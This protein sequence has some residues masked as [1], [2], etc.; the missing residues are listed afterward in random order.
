MEIDDRVAAFLDG[1]WPLYFCRTCIAANL[2]VPV[3]EVKIGLLRLAYFRGRKYCESACERCADCG[4]ET[5]V[6]RLRR[7]R[8]VA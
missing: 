1:T 7:L 5:A 2:T 8:R 3:R 6:T 4:M